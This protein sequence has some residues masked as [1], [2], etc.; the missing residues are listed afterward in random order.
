MKRLVSLAIIGVLI[1]ACSTSGV[2]PGAGATSGS[3][4]GPITTATPALDSVSEDCVEEA[5]DFFDAL[6][7]LDSRLDV[8]LNFADYSE[9]VGDAKVAYD[10]IDVDELDPRCIV[11]AAKAEDAYNH[12]AEAYN[13]WNG[14]I[15]DADCDN[16]SIRPALQAEWA[17]ASDLLDEVEEALP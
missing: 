8:G 9:R 6:M 16:D 3:A 1:G 13:T 12:Y 4:D 15:G 5:G 11:I 17:D 7:D 14:C 2:V 10:R